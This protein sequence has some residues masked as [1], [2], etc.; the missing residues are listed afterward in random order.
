MNEK[1]NYIGELV[2]FKG[3]H[4]ETDKYGYKAMFAKLLEEYPEVTD[5]SKLVVE[6][7]KVWIIRDDGQES[8]VN[9]TP[10]GKAI[11]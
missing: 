10:K 1:K 6:G 7:N 9:R 3:T 8:E 2:D 5:P 11:E 4:I